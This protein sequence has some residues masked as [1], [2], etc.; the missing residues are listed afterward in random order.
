MET[1]ETAPEPI[2]KSWKFWLVWG[3]IGGF[4][5]LLAFGFSTD[6]RLVPSPLVGKAAMDFEGSDVFT[7]EKF[8]LS[9]NR[10]TPV[11]VN[12]WASW[13]VECRR[14]A[15]I[16][17]QFYQEYGL[18]ENPRVRVV[19]IAIQDTQDAARA[20]AKKYGKNYFL[21]LDQPEGT[22][23]LNYGIYG[24]PETFFVDQSGIIRYK[25]VGGVTPTVMRTWIEKMLE[26]QN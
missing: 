22:I 24:V 15:A 11:I 26:G 25:H 19:G 9:E 8:K 1:V 6:P 23:A 10:G 3:V 5:A 7:S 13:C 20:F 17:E 18:G 12:F 21:T 16:L 2:W 14:E 4:I